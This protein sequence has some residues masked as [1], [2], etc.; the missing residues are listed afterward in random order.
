[1]LGNKEAWQSRIDQGMDVIM[2]S[3]INGKGAMPPRGTCAEC[4]D[5]DLRAAVQ[6]MISKVQ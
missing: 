3:V 5:D 6:Y 4:S 1:M 2:H